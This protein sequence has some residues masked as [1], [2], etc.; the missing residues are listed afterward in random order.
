MSPNDA[1]AERK[2]KK[3]KRHLGFSSRMMAVVP[4]DRLKNEVVDLY[5]IALLFVHAISFH[6]FWR[7]FVAFFIRLR[8]TIFKMFLII[9]F[10]RFRIFF[11]VFQNLLMIFFLN[12][13]FLKEFFDS[14]CLCS[15]F[16]TFFVKARSGSRW[17]DD[18]ENEQKNNVE[19]RVV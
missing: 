16:M 14:V 13:R 8:W 6:I 15:C 4:F 2:K 7:F 3:F 12:D 18:L 5:E 11:S 1:S 10:L 9:R 17:N 19:N